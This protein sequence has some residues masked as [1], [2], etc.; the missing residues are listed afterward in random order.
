[1]ETSDEA[2]AGKPELPPDRLCVVD[3][4][5]YFNAAMLTRVRVWIDEVE[6]ID[7]VVEYCVSGSWARVHVRGPNGQFRQ[8][9]YGKG[10]MIKRLVNVVVRVEFK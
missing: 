6:H 8:N 5:P 1:M 2:L 10:L 9:I 4:K 7:D 3:G